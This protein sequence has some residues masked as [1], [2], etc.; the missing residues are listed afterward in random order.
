[1]KGKRY[2][3]MMGDFLSYFLRIQ[4]CLTIGFCKI[5]W[6]IQFFLIFCISILFYEHA[7]FYLFDFNKTTFRMQLDLNI[8][9]KKQMGNFKI[10]MLAHL[11]QSYLYLWSQDT[12]STWYF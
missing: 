6:I 1:M 5:E 7:N 8:H 10:K 3:E 11:G 4:F 9:F 12:L 2:F